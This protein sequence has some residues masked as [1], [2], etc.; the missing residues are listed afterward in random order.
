MTGNRVAMEGYLEYLNTQILG[1][2]ENNELMFAACINPHPTNIIIIGSPGT[3][4]TTSVNIIAR[5]LGQTFSKVQAT[6]NL[7]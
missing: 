7:D 2:R 1:N 6:P 3:S 5:L 4:K